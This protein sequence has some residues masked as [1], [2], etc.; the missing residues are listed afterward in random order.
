MEAL[1]AGAGV[2]PAT[3]GR[4]DAIACHVCPRILGMPGP[5]PS[6]SD[7]RVGPQGLPESCCEPWEQTVSDQVR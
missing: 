3:H 1:A 4:A 7:T 2:S 5:S 6:P